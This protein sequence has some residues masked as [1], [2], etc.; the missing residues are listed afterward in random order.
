MYVSKQC[1]YMTHYDTKPEDNL[2]T[3]FI[4]CVMDFPSGVGTEE[5]QGGE[6]LEGNR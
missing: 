1:T 2:S 6:N 5:R 4:T 3:G